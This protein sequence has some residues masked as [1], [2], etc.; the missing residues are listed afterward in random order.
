MIRL[1]IGRCLLW[2]I[3]PAFGEIFN[4]HVIAGESLGAD[5]KLSPQRQI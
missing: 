2:L 4:R 1:F 5:Q 3:K